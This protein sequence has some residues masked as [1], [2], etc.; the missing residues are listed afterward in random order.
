MKRIIE[1]EIIDHGVEHE[2]Y[3]Q[4]C[5]VSHTKFD[6]VY[7]GIGSTLREA[8]RDADEQMAG[9]LGTYLQNDELEEEIETAS[10]ES[11]PACSYETTSDGS[12]GGDVWHYASIRVRIDETKE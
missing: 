3:F 12:G 7:T 4:G 9:S 1:Y 10:N 2:Q 11:D 6:E 8:L 5:G